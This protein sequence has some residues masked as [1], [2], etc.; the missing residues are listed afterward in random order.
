MAPFLVFEL[1]LK[2]L[3]NTDAASFGFSLP[4]YIALI[5][6]LV[7]ETFAQQA[8]ILMSPTGISEDKR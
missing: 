4:G 2:V 7:T 8:A 5:N 3:I 1:A 6:Q